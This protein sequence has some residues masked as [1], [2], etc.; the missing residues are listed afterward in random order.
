MIERQHLVAYLNELLEIGKFKDYC[1]NGLQV[2]GKT[3]IYKLVTGVTASLALVEAALAANAD[4]ILVHHGYFWKGEAPTVQ[5]MKKQRLAKLL[6]A[7]VSLLAY[8]LPLDAHPEYGNNAQLGRLWGIK[9]SASLDNE[10][11]VLHG[12]FDQEYTGE[13]VT[14]LLTNTLQR[15]PLHISASRP[16]KR[17][18]WCS[19]GAQGYIEAAVASGVDAYISGEISEQT[20]HIARESGIHYFAAGHHATERYGARALGEHVATQL[21]IECEFVDIDNPA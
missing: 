3:E 20:T 16:I 7:D 5:G 4:A 12:E 11:L 21:G 18:A 19:G 8:H 17:L 2:E 1:P 6:A 14:Q 15:V 10:T 13:F 9:N